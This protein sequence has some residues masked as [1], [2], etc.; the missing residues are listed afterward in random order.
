MRLRYFHS[1]QHIRVC[2][3]FFDKDQYLIM[4]SLA[5]L[6]AIYPSLI[7]GQPDKLCPLSAVM[8]QSPPPLA[9]FV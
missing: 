8:G 2:P 5:T 7:F 6:L 9:A 4:L 1:R 3:T